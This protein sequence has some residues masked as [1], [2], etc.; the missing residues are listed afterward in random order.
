M[1]LDAGP[2]AVEWEPLLAGQYRRTSLHTMKQILQH[3]RSGAVTVE[4]VPPPCLRG[5][6]LLVL[7]EASLISP[8]TRACFLA[9][10]SL[11]SGAAHQL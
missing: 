10:R 7:N 2:A 9:V 8:G 4:E 11:S 5:N 3:K 6:G 1:G